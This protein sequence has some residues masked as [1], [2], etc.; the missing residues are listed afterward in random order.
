MGP[1]EE[2][3]SGWVRSTE[4]EEL[5]GAKLQGESVRA[6][7][8]STGAGSVLLKTLRRGW[9]PWDGR[10]KVGGTKGL[11]YGP[12]PSDGGFQTPEG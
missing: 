3:G 4:A 10:G 9:K 6:G 7:P 2:V 5:V 11:Q 1:E 12:L 8:Q